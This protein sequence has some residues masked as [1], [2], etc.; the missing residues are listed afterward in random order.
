MKIALKS[1]PYGNLPYDNIEYV[2]KM[3]LK[4]FED[5][6]YLPFLPKISS[7]DNITNRTLSNIPGVKIKSRQVLFDN[8]SE[9]FKKK[10]LHLDDAFNN[11][12]P[13]K[14]EAYRFSAIYLEKYLQIIKRLQPQETI[15]NLLGPFSISQMLMNKN[16]EQ[17]LAD[18]SIRKLVVQSVCVKALWIINQINKLSPDTLPIIMLEEPLLNKFGSI[19]R[20]CEEVTTDLVT[21][22]YSKVIKKIQEHGGAVGIQSFEKC[23]WQI[24]IN[25]EA[26]II[27]FNAYS[28]PN[29]LNIIAKK[30]NEFLINGGHINWG[31]VPVKNESTIKAYSVDKAYDHFLKT[32]YG[33]IDSGVSEKLAF[34]RASVSVQGHV[35]K[36]AIIFAEKSLI[37]SSQLAKKIPF[38]D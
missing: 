26:D 21:N 30:V 11:P 16:S 14:L 24:P 28:H 9:N 10:I 22:I 25:A 8:T 7:A 27:S 12:T 15:I 32:I 1:M 38:K 31:I 29:N 5:T 37:I 35:D 13:D 6:P 3:M 18:K 34:N 23:D 19:K 2:T 33:L 17:F 4:L 36:L 20:N